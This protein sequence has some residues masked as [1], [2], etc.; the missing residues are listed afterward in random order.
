MCSFTQCISIQEGS[1]RGS[2]RSLAIAAF[3]AAGGEATSPETGES[4]DLHQ[5]IGVEIPDE[6][7]GS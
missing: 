3:L 6:I 7:N 4:L 5:M 2:V 1:A